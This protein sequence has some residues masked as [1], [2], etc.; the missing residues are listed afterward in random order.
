MILLRD[1]DAR[2]NSLDDFPADTGDTGQVPD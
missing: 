2:E 1:P